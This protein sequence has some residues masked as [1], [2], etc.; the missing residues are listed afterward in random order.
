MLRN[1]KSDI[2]CTSQ[3][4][5]FDRNKEIYVFQNFAAKSNVLFF[6]RESK[7]LDFAERES[8]QTLNFCK[9]SNQL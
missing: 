9:K 2:F 8:Q 4:T 7:D 1:G 5:K 3:I 6:L